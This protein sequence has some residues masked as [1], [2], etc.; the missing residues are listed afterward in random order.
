MMVVVVEAKLVK[1]KDKVRKLKEDRSL[2]HARLQKMHTEKWRMRVVCIAL[3]L[4]MFL[5]LY[6]Y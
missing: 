3:M 5:W 2:L 4:V 1:K 6:M